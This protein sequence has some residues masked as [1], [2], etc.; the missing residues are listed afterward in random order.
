MNDFFSDEEIK[1]L[2]S[3][4]EDMIGRKI[5]IRILK[6]IDT[7][8]S[9][10]L[11]KSIYQKK[12]KIGEFIISEKNTYVN[13]RGEIVLSEIELLFSNFLIINNIEYTYGK[14][15][16]DKKYGTK[17]KYDFK[18]KDDR[19]NDIY[20]EIWGDIEG[21]YF[22]DYDK[23]YKI[24]LKIY[25]ANEL[26]LES[27]DCKSLYNKSYLRLYEYFCIIIS[28]YKKN[29]VFNEFNLEKFI[30]G[31]YVD[32]NYIRIQLHEFI[33]EN[34]RMPSSDELR[35]MGKCGVERYISKFGGMRE[36]AK[37]LG[38]DYE[39]IRFNW[40][41]NNSKEEF[42]TLLK[43]VNHIPTDN[44]YINNDRAGLM[45][46]LRK[47]K[48]IKKNLIK[49]AKS[50]GYDYKINVTKWDKDGNIL[51]NQIEPICK[52]LGYIPTKSYLE[53]I[54]RSDIEAAIQKFGGRDKLSEKLGLPTYNKY[55]GNLDS[56]ELKYNIEKYENELME[57]SKDIGYIPTEKELEDMEKS[58]LEKY[59]REKGGRLKVEKILNVPALISNRPYTLADVISKVKELSR[60]RNYIITHDELKNEGMSG[61]SN[62]ILKF[63]GI[64]E[65][66]KECNLP[67][68]NQFYNIKPDNYWTEEVVIRELKDIAKIQGYIPSH[69]EL[70][71]RKL[72]SLSS[73]IS[74]YGGYKCIK[75]KVGYPTY[76]E[77][78]NIREKGTW[79]KEGKK[80]KEELI[81][82]CE[83][84]GYIPTSKYLISKNLGSIE[85]AI[86]KFGGWPAV[87]NLVNYPTYTDY[88]KLKKVINKD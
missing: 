80:L 21:K 41:T 26:I 38:I 3:K 60:D 81:P 28:K 44:D 53:N 86:R 49:L 1:T 40:N 14:C 84:L 24:K 9:V 59:I 43:K 31:S 70:K 73:A 23:K 11:Y 6:N 65:I 25:S 52:S 22:K 33:S 29:I 46:Y 71:E 39:N 27:I 88:R 4:Y 61:L 34:K 62:A 18:I 64:E 32:I 7:E 63:G 2:V 17:Y 16:P 56:G 50:M 66:A 36:V 82:L 45:R 35:S 87:A 68:Y 57:I 15:I 74:K 47:H 10:K 55:I 85:K 48:D 12:G 79:D 77:Y 72:S 54:G 83:K 5:T 75:E 8:E 30:Y 51:V 67:T 20:I 58:Y 78:Y 42:I 76:E 19:G 37:M 69:S 13:I